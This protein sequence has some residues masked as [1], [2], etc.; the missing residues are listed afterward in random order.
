MLLFDADLRP[1][2]NN[3]VDIRLNEEY[4]SLLQTEYLSYLL[5]NSQIKYKV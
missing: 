2:N 3:W 1:R 5:E 4:L